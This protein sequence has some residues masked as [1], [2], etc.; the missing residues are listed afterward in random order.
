MMG[1]G[2][3]KTAYLL[4]VILPLVTA[5]HAQSCLIRVKKLPIKNLTLKPNCELSVKYQFEPLKKVLICY[6]SFI[7]NAGK[8]SW[9]Y[10]G[11]QSSAELPTILSIDAGDKAELIDKSGKFTVLNDQPKVMAVNCQLG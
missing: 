2:M 8:I 4:C 6:T 9:S 3:K 7:Q 1:A 11:K 5:V 10:Q